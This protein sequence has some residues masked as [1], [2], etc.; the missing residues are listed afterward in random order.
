MAIHHVS[1]IVELDDWAQ[2]RVCGRTAVLCMELRRLF[3]ELLL[4]KARDPRLNVVDH[5]VTALISRVLNRE[6]GG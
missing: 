2:F 6:G 5:P 3:D 1:G 4:A